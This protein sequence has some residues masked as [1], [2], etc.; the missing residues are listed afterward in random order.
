MNKQDLKKFFEDTLSIKHITFKDGGTY[1]YQENRP[2]I[3]CKDGEWVSVQGS[4]SH[5][6]RPRMNNCTSYFRVEAGYPSVIP[7]E[8]WFGYAESY[9]QDKP[10]DYT[11]VIYPYILTSLILEFVNAHGGIDESVYMKDA[12]GI[13]RCVLHWQYDRRKFK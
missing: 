2:A 13:L 12:D 3:F 10:I 9:G 6:S 4:E 5:Y 11:K 8:S 1:T 7:P